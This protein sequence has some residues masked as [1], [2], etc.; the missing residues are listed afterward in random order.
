MA[1]DQWNNAVRFDQMPG[2][3]A[4]ATEVVFDIPVLKKVVPSCPEGS[5]PL[6]QKLWF[7]VS[8]FLLA[9]S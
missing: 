5:G 2:Y 9:A 4:G 7:L 8:L 6:Q 3:A 1:I